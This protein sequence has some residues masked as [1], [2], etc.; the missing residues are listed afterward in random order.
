MVGFDYALASGFA[1]SASGYR[2]EGRAYSSERRVVLTVKYT[3]E[4]WNVEDPPLEE[5][6]RSEALALP[7]NIEDPPLEDWVVE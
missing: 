2:P 1:F 6:A 7:W 3:M 4:K 5:W